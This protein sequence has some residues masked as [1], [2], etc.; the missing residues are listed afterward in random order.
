ML[1]AVALLRQASLSSDDGS[2][3]VGLQ[4]LSLGTGAVSLSQGEA[5]VEVY[6]QR[7]TGLGQ[8]EQQPRSYGPEMKL[9]SPT[10]LF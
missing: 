5:D 3:I 1:P 10:S 7:R 8:K 9:S 4:F 6:L 2:A